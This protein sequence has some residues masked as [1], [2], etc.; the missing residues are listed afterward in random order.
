MS[1]YGR[2][3]HKRA[4]DPGERIG[5]FVVERRLGAGAMG[6]VLLAHDPELDRPV[7]IKLLKTDDADE[8]ARARLVREAQSA[9]RVSHPNVVAVHQV[10]T[11]EGQV[12]VV[13]EYVD[14]GTLRQW[15]EAESRSC[16]E[17]LAAY[18]QA[19]EGL[20]AAHAA[21]LVHRDF[22]P[23]NVL[24]GRDARVRVSDFG[25]VGLAG[26]IVERAPTLETD[27]TDARLTRTGAVMGTP[28]YMPPE[29]YAGQ[30][31]DARSDQFSFC[32][33]LFEALHGTRPFEGD[34]L[35]S[36]LCSIEEG[37]VRRPTRSDV[38]HAIQVALE[39]GLSTDPADRHPNMP[40]LLEALA[41]PKR[42]RAGA[43]LVAAGGV[44]VSG[45]LAA[46]YIL[47]PG[48]MGPTAA[49]CPDAVEAYGSAW[50]EG[51]RNEVKAGLDG[52]GH[53]T[54]NDV[55]THLDEELT[56]RRAAWI[57]AFEQAC[58]THRR[59]EQTQT[60]FELRST[61]LMRLRDE[62]DAFSA[63]VAEGD[64][65]LVDGVLSSSTLLR[66]IAAC[67]D[68]E[69]LQAAS[70]PRAEV[71][72]RLAP[73]RRELTRAR[74]LLLAGR[75]HD[76]LSSTRELETKLREVG[77]NAD[78]AAALVV[79]ARAE[80]QLGEFDDAEAHLR[81][82]MTLAAKARAHAVEA[83]ATATLMYVVGPGQGRYE[84]ALGMLAAGEAAAQRSSDRRAA[85]YL[86]AAT[87]T[88]LFATG[89]T[90]EAM[91]A[92]DGAIT[93]LESFERP[94]PDELGNAYSNRA[95]LKIKLG[96]VK[97][98]IA[99]YELG[100]EAI[101]RGL[102]RRHPFYGALALSLGNTLKDTGDPERALEQYTAALQAWEATY[103]PDHTSCALARV[104]EA[105]A[106][107]ARD[108]LEE[109][110]KALEDA[111]GRHER[112][113]A[114][115]PR[116][117]VSIVDNLAWVAWR[118]GRFDDA[119]RDYARAREL[120]L[121]SADENDPRLAS[122]DEALASILRSRGRPAEAVPLLEQARARHVDRHG[123]KHATVARAST[124]I[125]DAHLQSRDCKAAL[126]H[127]RTAIKIR[128]DL[129]LP[130]DA[131]LA[132]LLTGLGTCELQA[133][134]TASATDSIERAVSLLEETSIE[135]E[136][137][138]RI[139]LAHARLLWTQGRH[140]PARQAAHT[141]VT[142]LQSL[143]PAYAPQHEEAR[144]WLGAHAR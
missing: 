78:L 115:D 98:A 122:Y 137:S 94:P 139:Q 100:L 36:L 61:C 53:R 144:I 83:R 63:L 123:P 11:H 13:M 128:N 21:G 99:D 138:A 70:P 92:F 68:V 66:P 50:S 55:F 49:A 120:V 51:R 131:G 5:T 15:V 80:M 16:S 40:T 87:G 135:P 104:Y 38:P 72:A 141:A 75:H 46:A 33:S 60:I 8:T 84:E 91:A 71:L 10:G 43:V 136:L 47:G 97:G 59:G 58:E 24:I 57:D 73:L 82:A 102:G 29:Q 1:G 30:R 23:D 106:H 118:Q 111:R 52:T 126:A 116:G 110:R 125:G 18:R 20:A 6:V 44:A 133:A 39:R 14:G 32:V 86:Q 67:A 48:P 112:A 37:R 107:M 54:S 4:P 119:K 124:L 77:V 130:P 56:A 65:R 22:K 129:E 74:I 12:Y 108:Q 109:A 142:T 76:V 62:A 35:A 85:T 45:V 28:A 42:S 134:D 101:A 95:G 140:E 81:E 79:A 143:G 17:V 96:D 64:E 27:D 90:D 105:Q 114:D 132:Q 9:A 34:T 2:R 3:N 25:L 113:G 26:D 69:A 121:A 7:A 88:V 41:P 89:K 31:M 117:L 127:Y 103:G 19:G 93:T